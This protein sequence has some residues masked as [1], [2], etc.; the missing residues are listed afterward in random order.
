MA[1][2]MRV[3]FEATGHASGYRIANNQFLSLVADA[4]LRPGA[5]AG[6]AH[7]SIRTATDV[8][9]LVPDG[10]TVRGDWQVGD[11]VLVLEGGDAFAM[12]CH[13]P[14]AGSIHVDTFSSLGA[15][16]AEE[17]LQSILARCTPQTPLEAEI[18][19]TFWGNTS[20]G[21]RSFLRPL[22]A[23]DWGDVADNYPGAIGAEMQELQGWSTPPSGGRLLLAHG[24]A[25]TGK[26]S[27]L[28][29]LARSWRSWCD[30]HYIVDPDEFF[31]Y[32]SYMLSVLLGGE[33]PIQLAADGTAM[34]VPRWR[35]IVVE[36]CDE[37]LTANAK[38]RSGQQVARLLNVCD[39]MVG[40]GLRILLFL[41]TNEKVDNFHEAIVRPGRCLKN[42]YFGDFA[43]DEADVWRQSRDLP[44]TG[45]PATLADLYA[46]SRAA[47]KSKASRIAGKLRS[48]SHD[49]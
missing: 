8:T 39:G 18:E 20:M 15:G 2:D 40:Q 46:E 45:D 19:C 43:G 4:A 42:L 29:T 13:D 36:D 21:P 26:T 44:V 30:V 25:G 34:S 33:E 35:L 41:T 32:A 12:V 37:L 16:V 3:G 6:Y 23:P 27:A 9:S 47:A 10:W 17:I 38:D 49:A 28:R 5:T 7:D 22:D 24:P 11:H 48:V 31:G 1:D 14:Y